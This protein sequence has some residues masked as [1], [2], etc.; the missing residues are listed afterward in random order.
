M[1]SR[2]NP[3]LSIIIPTRE[4]A[5]TLGYT[6]RTV[7]DQ[8]T[9][10]FEVIVSDNFSQDNTAQVVSSFSDPRIRLINPGRRLSMCD[11]WDFALLHAAGDYVMFIGDDDAILPGALDKLEASILSTH[12]LVYGW[13]K[14]IYVWPMDGKPARVEDLHRVRLKPRRL[15][16]R[17]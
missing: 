8:I 10:N 14:P 13:P 12:S 9:R 5:E 1:S 17:S 15:I 3:L 7:L 11:H 2:S 16:W 6:L 4:R